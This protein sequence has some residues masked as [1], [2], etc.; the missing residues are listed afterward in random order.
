ME[1]KP[2][3]DPT[4]GSRIAKKPRLFC[5]EA[6]LHTDFKRIAKLQVVILKDQISVLRIYTS[7]P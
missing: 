5:I 3:R 6:G 4:E 7:K 1:D 2:R